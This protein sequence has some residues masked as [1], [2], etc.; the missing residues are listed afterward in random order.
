MGRYGDLI[1][2]YLIRKAKDTKT[3]LSIEIAKPEKDTDQDVT[4]AYTDRKGTRR[5]ITLDAK[6]AH[7]LARVLKAV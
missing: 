6:S 5:I 7:D 1:L 3:M 4:I 2:G